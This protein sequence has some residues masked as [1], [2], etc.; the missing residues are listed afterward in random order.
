LSRRFVRPAAEGEELRR[1]RDPAT[2]LP[3]PPEGC[4]VE[5]GAYWARREDDGDVIA[6]KHPPATKKD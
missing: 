4:F 3:L 5:W 6:T 2:G 1:V